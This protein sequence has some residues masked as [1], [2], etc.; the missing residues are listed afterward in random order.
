[1]KYKNFLINFVY[2]G[3]KTEFIVIKKP[4]KFE[5]TLQTKKHKNKLKC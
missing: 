5:I 3:K 1:M 2:L 4:I